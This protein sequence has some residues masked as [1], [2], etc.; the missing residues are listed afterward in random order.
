M[1]FPL[2]S[3]CKVRQSIQRYLHLETMQTNMF[4]WVISNFEAILYFILNIDTPIR[5]SDFYEL[6][7]NDDFYKTN[8][9]SVGSRRVIHNFYRF[10]T[11]HDFTFFKTKSYEEELPFFIDKYNRRLNRLK[12]TIINSEKIDFIHLVDIIPN[13]R[14]PEQN[15]YIPTEEQ[16]W[17][18]VWKMKQI[19]PNCVCNLHILIPPPYCKYYKTEF[20]VNNPLLERLSQI[21]NI[22]I[23]FL[24]QNENVESCGDQCCHWS[25]D[26]VYKSIEQM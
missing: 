9:E 15:I 25:W 21:P 16:L 20:T 12:N 18:F 14:K 19:N 2:G 17:L 6:K 1:L 23:H 13:H 7:D 24:S 8:K 22:F 4:D 3:A 26:E 10:D 5:A 11:I